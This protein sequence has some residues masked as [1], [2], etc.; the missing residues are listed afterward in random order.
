MY[1]H[2]ELVHNTKAAREIFPLVLEKI[3]VQ[4]LLDIGCGIG[5]WLFVA[6]DLGIN[7]VIG[8]DGDYVD[9]NLLAKYLRK[10]EFISHDLTKPLN[11]GRKFDICLCL[12]VAEHLA[13]NSADILI[14][15]LVG[16]SD[17]ILFSAAIPGQGGQNHV[18]EQWPDYWAKKFAD[19]DYVFLDLIR[20][21]IWNNPNVDYWYR[22]NVFFVVKNSHELTK[23]YPQSHLSLIHPELYLSKNAYHER[24]ISSLQNQIA[25]HPLK[26]WIKKL[27]SKS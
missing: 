23:K 14:D 22:Q 19:R 24:K 21:L 15:T 2:E 6:K 9:K 26:R 4:S 16:H 13:E 18:N 10:E 11:L 27:I 3:N 5:T 8:I 25:V 7:E 20:P 17:V 12:E 1:L